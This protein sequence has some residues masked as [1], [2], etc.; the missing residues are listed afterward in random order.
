MKVQRKDIG[1]KRILMAYIRYIILTSSPVISVRH[2]GS[3]SPSRWT[4]SQA[5]STILL[6]HITLMAVGWVQSLAAEM[7]SDLIGSSFYNTN[8]MVRNLPGANHGC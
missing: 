5:G 4:D 1:R 8:M 3:L 7:I 2:R 6:A